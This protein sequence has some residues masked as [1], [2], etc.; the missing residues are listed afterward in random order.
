[1]LTTGRIVYHWHTRTKTGRVPALNAA[2]PEAFVEVQ[3]GDAERLGIEEGDVVE[4]KTRRGS[5][6]VPARLTGIEP[7]VLFIPF[8]YGSWDDPEMRTAAN[9][10]TISGWDPVSKQ[11]TFK[12]AAASLRRVR[13]AEPTKRQIVVVDRRGEP[14]TAGKAR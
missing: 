6:R 10:L 9:E 4:V 8:H 11:P 3:R 7:G 2:A 1:M 12:Y 13:E 5:V 14:V